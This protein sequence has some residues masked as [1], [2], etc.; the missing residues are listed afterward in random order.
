MIRERMEKMGRIAPAVALI[1]LAGCGGQQDRGGEARGEATVAGAKAF[2]EQVHADLKA[3]WADAARA[4]WVAETYITDDTGQIA[5]AAHEDVLAYNTKAIQEAARFNGL[6]LDDFTARTMYLLK[7]SSPAPAPADAEKRGTLARTMSEMGALYGKGKWCPGEGDE[8]CQDLG[9]L[10]KIMARSRDYDEQL[11]AWRRWRTVSP[12]MKPLYERFVTL[13]NEGAKEIGFTDLGDLWRSGYDMPAAEFEAEAERLWQQVQP[14]YEAL[15]CHVRAK[16]A[17]QYPGK[18]KDSGTLPAHLMGN[19]W[20]QEWANLYPILE[21]FPGKASLDVTG[22]LERQQWGAVK[23][24]KA[25]EAFFT[26]LG[27]KPLPESFY[28]RSMLTKPRDRDVVCHASAWDVT[29]NNDVRIKMCIRPTEEDLI[30]IHHEL[31][32]IYYYQYYH[33]RP[34]LFQNGAHDGFHEAI[35]DALA[36]S[37]TPAYLKALGLLDAVPEDDEGLLNVQLKTALDKIAFLPFG[38][39][40]DQWR[41]DVFSGKVTPDQWNDHWWALRAKYQGLHA[42]VERP[43]GAFDPGAKYHIPANT[44]YVRY[45]LSFIIQFQFYKA[46]CEAAGHEGPLHTCNF[47]GSK[48]AGDKLTAMLKMGASE[49]WPEAMEALTGQR[50]MSAEPLL[51]YFAPLQAWLAEQNKDR[52][53][54]W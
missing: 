44:P 45:F 1:C 42:P 6:E 36:L 19:M 8:G 41:W 39:M 17:E 35:G 29:Y 34:V 10:S 23:M 25:G 52:T 2:A 13:G 4:E 15:H 32:H 18:V 20:A 24:V 38:R 33:Q 12:A 48:A 3:L 27:M 14:L 22:A 37:V 28:E 11:Q 5:A 16:L 7:I 47:A 49:P 46:L 9:A 31:G 50:Q 43:A 53:C 21:P 26:G 51:E 40:I 54:G 30:T